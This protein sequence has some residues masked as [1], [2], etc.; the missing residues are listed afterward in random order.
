MLE[1]KMLKEAE[2]ICE[3][4]FPSDEIGACVLHHHLAVFAELVEVQAMIKFRNELMVEAVE[5]DEVRHG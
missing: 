3:E 1:E 2:R 5:I 4:M